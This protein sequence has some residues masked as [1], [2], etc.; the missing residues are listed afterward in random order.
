MFFVDLPPILSIDRSISAATTATDSDDTRPRNRD[1]VGLTTPPPPSRVPKSSSL[2]PIPHPNHDHHCKPRKIRSRRRAPLD[3]SSSSAFR[4][5][6]ATNHACCARRSCGRDGNACAARAFTPAVERYPVVVTRNISVPAA[7]APT[8]ASSTRS[9]AAA[10]SGTR[11]SAGY[12]QPRALTPPHTRASI[13][14]HSLFVERIPRQ[15]PPF[16][17]RGSVEF[18]PSD[19]ETRPYARHLCFRST[20]STYPTIV[21]VHTYHQPYLHDLPCNF[22]SLI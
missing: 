9:N 11:L 15:F 3:A 19:A 14:P 22:S 13:P 4:R 21:L 7:S 1:T 10:N 2:R 5:T 12:S 8:C 6:V 20:P 18:V 16:R 17:H